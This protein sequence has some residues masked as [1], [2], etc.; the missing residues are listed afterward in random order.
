MDYQGM[1]IRDITK[2]KYRHLLML[3]YWPVYTLVYFTVGHLTDHYTPIHCMIDDMIPFNEYFI[4]LYILWYPFWIGM[5][6]YALL[7]EVETFKKLMKYLILTFSIAVAT[8]VLFP[9]GV[10][11]RPETFEDN[12]FC[13]W[14]TQIIYRLDSNTNVM[15][16]EHV[17]AAVGTVFAAMDSKRF[18]T[19]FRLTMTILIAVAICASILLVKQHSILD[20]GAALIVCIVGY[21]ICFARHRRRD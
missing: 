1:T 13:T 17:I 16:S 14:L 10:D 20:I 12:N 9:T 7:K 3:L 19:P 11:F 8:Y 4:I 2:P 18:S 15:P 5:V 21:I 6:L